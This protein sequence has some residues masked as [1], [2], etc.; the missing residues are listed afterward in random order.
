M[1]R[2]KTDLLTHTDVTAIAHSK[3]VDRNTLEITYNNGDRA[4]R[5]HD[6]DIAIFKINGDII[7]N[8]GGWK[9][10]TTKDRLNKFTPF[11]ISQN[12]GIWYINDIIVF[13][14][15]MILDNK[16]K[17]KSKIVNVDFKK[18]NKIKKDISKYISLIDTIEILPIPNDGDCWH[19]LFHT[20][21]DNTSLGD[22]TKDNTHL[23]DHIKEGYLHGSI[24]VNAMRENG[25]RD[26]QIGL[27][28]QMNLRDTFKRALRRYLYKR[29][30]IQ[31]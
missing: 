30:I 2:N 28:Y 3:F 24:L 11:S 12:K 21:T 22:A 4:I 8:T 5:L 1:R 26:E 17:L 15:G 25:Y 9:T 18:I 13:Y 10:T 23:T 27:D 29:L 6:T 14:D 19:C 31:E 7:L 20:T 16:G